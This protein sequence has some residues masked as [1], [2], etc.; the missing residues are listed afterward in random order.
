MG[1]GGMLI[2]MISAAK[3]DVGAQGK[4]NKKMECLVGDK[5]RDNNKTVESQSI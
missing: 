3:L 1:R 2:Q 4:R 5:S